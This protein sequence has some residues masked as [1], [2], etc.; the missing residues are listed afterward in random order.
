MGRSLGVSSEV[1]FFF[2]FF[3]FFFFRGKFEARSTVTCPCLCC[4]LAPLA[5]LALI[6]HDLL[7]I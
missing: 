5:S 2:F 6:Q 3:F 7:Y 4:T 1:G